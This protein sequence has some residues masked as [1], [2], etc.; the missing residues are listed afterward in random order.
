MSRFGMKFLIFT[1]QVMFWNFLGV[2]QKSMEQVDYDLSADGQLLTATSV[3]THKINLEAQP[4]VGSQV[5]SVFTLKHTTFATESVEQMPF[6]TLEEAI[7]S[8]LEWYRVFDIEADVDGVI[9]E[10]KDNTVSFTRFR[11]IRR[12]EK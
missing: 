12:K 10:I 6:K 2:H 7:K 9:S 4:E 5:E 1:L 11:T 8:L 3:E